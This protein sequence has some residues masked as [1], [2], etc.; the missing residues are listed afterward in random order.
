METYIN[1]LPATAM[2]AIRMLANTQTS[3]DVMSDQ[4]IEAV[5]NGEASALE[6]M[7][8]LNAF[9][10][11]TERVKKEIKENVMNEADKYHERTFEIMGNKFEKSELGTKYDYSACG[12]L[13]YH[14]LLGVSTEAS[15]QVKERENFLKALKH[16]ITLVDEE[17]GEVYTVTPPLKTSTS[18]I[19]I[20][21]R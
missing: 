11:V 19:K 13:I 6:L 20:T 3:I 10:K 2:G 4:L 5:K 8:F 7:V 9:E 14:R 17:S 18:G 12:D 16:S 21:I 15:K 1:E